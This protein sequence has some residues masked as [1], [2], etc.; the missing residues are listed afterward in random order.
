MNFEVTGPIK[1]GK[2]GQRYKLE[3]GQILPKR[4]FPKKDRIALWEAGLIIESKE[5]APN[6]E[7]DS[8]EVPKLED[9]TIMNVSTAKEFL[10][11]VPHVDLL[12]KY[13]DQA[14]AEEFPR[15]T[16]IQFIERRIR[17]LTNTDY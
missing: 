5:E 15:K 11:G 17:E 3:K 13:L 12:E 6:K 16:I 10:E 9:L 2:D 7:P 1:Y 14:N 8:V 4:F